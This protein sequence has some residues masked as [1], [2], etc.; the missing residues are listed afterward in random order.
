MRHVLAFVH[1]HVLLL[2]FCCFLIQISNPSRNALSAFSPL[3]FSPLL[4]SSLLVSSRLFSS[5]LASPLLCSPLLF[6]PLL[7]SS[8]L[9]PSSRLYS[10]LLFACLAGEKHAQCNLAGLF[11]EGEG[12]A[13]DMQQVGGDDDDDENED[14]NYND[15]QTKPRMRVR[16][17][18]HAHPRAC[19]SARVFVFSPKKKTV[20]CAKHAICSFCKY[21]QLTTGRP[22]TG[23][24][25][26][27]TRVSRWPSTTS[28]P[29]TPMGRGWNR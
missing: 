12:V 5:L 18:A 26:P 15:G 24:V 21:A 27:Q 9:S 19:T 23:A 7:A 13:K 11:Q 1:T 8:L 28:A 22:R 20:A 2:R 16:T 25:S 29:C 3:L 17:H 6:S 4:F 14:G 10:S